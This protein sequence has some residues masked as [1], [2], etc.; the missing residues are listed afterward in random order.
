VTINE[1]AEISTSV[2]KMQLIVETGEC[3]LIDWEIIH[4]L[5]HPALFLI[6]VWCHIS[7]SIFKKFFVCLVD[8]VAK[9]QIFD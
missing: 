2:L 8:S 5:I 4:A 6:K 7:N 3:V 1:P 9:K